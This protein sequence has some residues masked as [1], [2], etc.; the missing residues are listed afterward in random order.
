MFVYKRGSKG[1]KVPIENMPPSISFREL[2]Q[3]LRLGHVP[4]EP[5]QQW[6]SVF[7]FK[8]DQIDDD[9]LPLPDETMLA[10]LGLIDGD[11]IYYDVIECIITTISITKYS[12]R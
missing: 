12:S 10:E 7:F 8:T 4:L 2:R 11:S 3:M 9:N 6:S 1:S 5:G